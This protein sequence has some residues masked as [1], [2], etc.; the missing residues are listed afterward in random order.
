MV[1]SG[2]K[3]VR[4]TSR[5]GARLASVARLS[6]PSAPTLVQA[7]WKTSALRR[8]S[9]SS[10]SPLGV[11]SASAVAYDAIEPS[12]APVPWVEV[13]RAPPR[14]CWSM[15]GRFGIARRGSGRV[16]QASRAGPD[17]GAERRG[18]HCAD[19]REAVEKQNS[20]GGR[21][22][23][24]EGGRRPRGQ[25]CPSRRA[26]RAQLGLAR[27][28]EPPRGRRRSSPDQFRQEAAA[29]AAVRS[30][31]PARAYAGSAAAPTP[32]ASAARNSSPRG[33]AGVHGRSPAMYATS[34]Q[35]RLSTARTSPAAAAPRSPFT[36]ARAGRLRLAR[37]VRPGGVVAD[38]RRAGARR[39]C[40][41]R[42]VW[43]A[44][45]RAEL[46]ASCRRRVSPLR[47]H[48][49]AR[50]S[51]RAVRLVSL[52]SASDFPPCTRA[53]QK[54]RAPCS[55]QAPPSRSRCLI[56]GGSSPREATWRR[57]RAPC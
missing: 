17:L 1:S 19:A 6:T 9:H 10:S 27:R 8:G 31:G 53:S 56:S 35:L 12:V 54:P 2:T 36:C 45:L 49:A 3:R 21:H 14:V 37:A 29:P 34:A 57:P 20:V 48:A 13:A 52:E 15:S 33:P 24:A 28:P 55:S 40:G 11:A 38:E 42:A 44:R 16:E 47:E 32:A 46:R 43:Y 25:A 50:I 22:E 51:P 41:K 39:A 7:A 5:N 4:S 23:R 30:I 18:V 26:A